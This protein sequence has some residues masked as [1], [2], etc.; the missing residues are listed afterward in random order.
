MKKSGNMDS[1]VGMYSSK[2][3]PLPAPRK[4]SSMCGPGSNPDQT[5]ANR[6]L[7]QAYRE[8]ESLRGKMGM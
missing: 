2:S 1:P 4:T 7:Q 5:K 8:K 3:N 6:L